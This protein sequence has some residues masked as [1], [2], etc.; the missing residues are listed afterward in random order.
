MIQQ[1]TAQNE[2]FDPAKNRGVEKV[3]EPDGRSA[4][5]YSTG[6]SA[7]RDDYVEESEREKREKAWRMLESV[8]IDTR[9]GRKAPGP[10]K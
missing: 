6:E 7:H 4:T 5:I 10:R 2:K 3:T 9:D 8:V 1:E